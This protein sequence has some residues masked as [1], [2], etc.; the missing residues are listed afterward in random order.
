MYA[1]YK[2]AISGDASGAR[3]GMLDVVGR[4]KFDS[5][6]KRRGLSHEQA[7][8]DYVELVTQLKEKEAATT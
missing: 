1:L 8:T 7:M 5:W 3:P 2:Q 4:A 6:E